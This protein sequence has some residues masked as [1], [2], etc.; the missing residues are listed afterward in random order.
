MRKTL[1]LCFYRRHRMYKAIILLSVIMLQGCAYGVFKGAMVVKDKVNPP[2]TAVQH[3]P[4]VD[5]VNVIACIKML[6]ECDV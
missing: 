2:E 1:L 4:F 5:K 3:E 6:D